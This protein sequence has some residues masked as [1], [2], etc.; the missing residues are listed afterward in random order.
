M[1]SA[2]RCC[3][4]RSLNCEPA[5]RRPCR[6]ITQARW[7][8][9]S[10]RL[11]CGSPALWMRQ[12]CAWFWSA[13]SDDRS[14]GEHAHL[15]RGWDHRHATGVHRAERPGSDGARTGAAVRPC[16]RLSR[17]ARRHGEAAVGRPRWTL[18]V[19]EAAGTRPLY[20]ASGRQRI[21]LA[22]TGAALD[23]ARRHRLETTGTNSRAGLERLGSERS[24]SSVDRHFS[25]LTSGALWHTS[26]MV[27]T[28][29]TL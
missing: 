28:P 18:P 29:I 9:R 15:D 23:A 17:T 16:L 2:Q 24:S 13:F 27:A 8:L 11:R 3:Q 20:L 5:T 10:A 6:W 7:N 19:P 25:L 26:H 22:D 4:T 1:E 21:G 14:S 12:R